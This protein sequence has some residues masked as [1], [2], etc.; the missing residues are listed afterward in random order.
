MVAFDTYLGNTGE[1]TLPGGATVANRA[2][3]LLTFGLDDDTALHHV[4]QAY[5]MNGLTVRFNLT[6]PDVQ[7]YQQHHH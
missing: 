1:S 4:T 2:E 5:D 3:F 7:K 6:D